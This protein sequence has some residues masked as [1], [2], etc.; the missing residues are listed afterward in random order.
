MPTSLSARLV[1]AAC[2]V[3]I[4]VAAACAPAA[5]SPSPMATASSP[6]TSSGGR[7]GA[8]VTTPQPLHATIA[9]AARTGFPDPEVAAAHGRELAMFE[10][11]AAPLR[12]LATRVRTRLTELERARAIAHAA[13]ER[14]FDAANTDR[15]DAA[16]RALV[17]ELGHLEAEMVSV[18]IDARLETRRILRPDQL[19][20]LRALRSAT[21]M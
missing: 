10:D 15:D 13:L 19:V 7:S 4:M 8:A 20:K 17:A 1:R 3:C 14:Q 9:L 6:A 5:N 16:I 12:A 2:A 21:S 18:Q 11:Q